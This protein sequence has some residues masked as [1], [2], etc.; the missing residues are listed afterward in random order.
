MSTPFGIRYTSF[1]PAGGFSL[2][3]QYLKIQG[4]DLHATEGAVG[5]AVR[6]D[7]LV[8]QM[9][10]M[11][12]MGV[13]ALRTAHNPPAPELIAACEQ[14]GIVMMVEAFD[15]WRHGKLAYD[16]HLYFDQWS[17]SDIKEM[18][19]AA[20]NSPAVVLWSI[21]NETPDTYMTD[22]PGDREA[23]DRGHQVG[24]TPRGPW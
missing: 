8:R 21:G 11:K 5:S 14:L 15:C 13:N 7:A 24:S 3:G 19:N 10:L 23:A 1:D 6:D 20:K 4:V 18:V 2:N 9:R 22:A 17:D 16:Y 12:S